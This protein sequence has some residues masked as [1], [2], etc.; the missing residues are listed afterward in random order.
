MATETAN[1]GL[2]QPAE[3]DYYDIGVQNGNMEKIDQALKSN[4]DAMTAAAEDVAELAGAGRTTE[5]VMGAYAAAGAAADA[6]AAAVAEKVSK[7]GD[8]MTGPLNLQGGMAVTNINGADG[9]TI[10]FKK[11]PDSTLAGDMTLGIY[12]QLVRF[13][14]GASPFRGAFIDLNKCA[15]NVGSEIYHTGFSP[16]FQISLTLPKTGWMA[17]GSYY[18]RAVTVNGITAAMMPNIDVNLASVSQDSWD[19]AEEAWSHIKRVVA[20]VNTLTFYANEIPSIALNL[21]GWWVN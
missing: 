5:T 17:S 2:V 16:R 1:Y 9:G 7:S 13:F 8:T 6:A 15:N 12:L 20:T 3:N 18:T 19:D 11:A 10:V 21:F 4:A 14:E